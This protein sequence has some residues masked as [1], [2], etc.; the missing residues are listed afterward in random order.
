MAVQENAINVSFN[1]IKFNRF[2][3][4]Y[5]ALLVKKEDVQN[6]VTKLLPCNFVTDSFAY[7]KLSLLSVPSLAR[8][9]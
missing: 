2:V 5:G 7:A 8:I 1:N 4:V 6:E 9:L 3:S